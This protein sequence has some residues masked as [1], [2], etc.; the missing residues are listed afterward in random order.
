MRLLA[1][2]HAV[3]TG[4][5]S[6][7]PR[8]NWTMIKDLPMHNTVCKDQYPVSEHTLDGFCLFRSIL[9]EKEIV[10][11][12]TGDPPCRAAATDARDRTTSTT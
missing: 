2:R 6:P 12:P 10:H 7:T 4:D 5:L 11:K 3:E 8:Q 9:A 1:G